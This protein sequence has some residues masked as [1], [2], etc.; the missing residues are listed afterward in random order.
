VYYVVAEALT[1]ATKHAQAQRSPSPWMPMMCGCASRCQTM[2]RP[3]PIL[4]VGAHRPEGPRGGVRR[5]M[6]ITSRDGEGTALTAEIP[7]LAA[8]P[9]THQSRYGTQRAPA[10]HTGLRAR[11]RPLGVR[12]ASTALRPVVFLRVSGRNECVLGRG[13]CRPQFGAE[14]DLHALGFT[15][16]VREYQRHQV[17]GLHGVHAASI[18]LPLPIRAHRS[19]LLPHP[20]S[21]RRRSGATALHP[22]DPWRR[23]DPRRRSPVLPARHARPGRW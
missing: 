13:Y 10:A 2:D 6:D 20:R 16:T 15:R 5:H 21:A 11:S 23:G 17:A 7:C 18:A 14:F 22:N 4:G 19:W 12:S 1:N 8:Y 9:D 3:V